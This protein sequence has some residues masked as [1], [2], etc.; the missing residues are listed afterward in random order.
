MKRQGLWIWLVCV[1]CV[2]GCQNDV[3]H[4]SASVAKGK[5]PLNKKTEAPVTPAIAV[6]D[7]NAARKTGSHVLLPSQR[8][9]ID[10][11]VVTPSVQGG[12]LAKA[13][14]LFS[15]LQ[16]TGK[17]QGASKS[18]AP[19]PLKVQSPPQDS[20]ARK[21]LPALFQALDAQIAKN[22]LL[23]PKNN[24]AISTLNAIKK[25]DPNHPD[26]FAYRD[27]LSHRLTE[28]G[29]VHYQTGKTLSAKT[30]LKNALLMNPQNE[31]AKQL[32]D[33]LNPALVVPTASMSTTTQLRRP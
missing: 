1:G 14:G 7:A 30:Y 10:S 20:Y 2:L 5:E 21:R 32:L 23:L 27:K 6:E 18:Q 16:G 24:N 28:V 33:A 29:S 12:F 19:S 8:S 31:R 25:A 11:A 3:I 13:G 22:Q 17:S 9:T 26:I 15:S 4:R